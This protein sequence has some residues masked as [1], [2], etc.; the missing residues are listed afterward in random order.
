M[1][2]GIPA[3][4][5]LLRHLAH[6]DIPSKMVM[7]FGA[8]EASR[9]KNTSSVDSNKSSG[10]LGHVPCSRRSNDVRFARTYESSVGSLTRMTRPKRALHLLGSSLTGNVLWTGGT[11]AGQCDM[12]RSPPNN[13]ANVAPSTIRTVTRRRKR[14]RSRWTRSLNKLKK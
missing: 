4:V 13:D 9:L 1:Q 2:S 14:L 12:T 10:A 7:Q 11:L 8:S 5:T 6:G 3:G